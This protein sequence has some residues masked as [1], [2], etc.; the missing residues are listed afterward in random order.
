[1]KILQISAHYYPNLGGVETHLLDLV[2]GLVKRG[3]DIFVLTYRPLT[4]NVSWKVFEH[5]NKKVILRIPYLPGLFY[6]LVT[7]PILEFLYLFPGL[8]LALPFVIIYHNPDV[9]HSHGLVAGTV[10]IFWGKVFGKK[11]VISL[12]S[13]YHFPVN[14]LYRSFVKVVFKMANKIICL[15]KQS[16]KE[17]EDLGI[18]KEKIK[19]FTY[20]I[21]LDRFKRD[22]K[23]K[24]KLG[25]NGKFVILFVGRLIPEKG[26]LELLESVRSWSDNIM[27]VIIGSGPL[28][29][30]ITS[31]KKLVNNL[32]FLGEVDNE[33]LPVYYSAADLLIVPSVH[34]EGF[35]RVILESLACGT[36][37][38]GSNRGAVPEAM[39]GTVGK[40]IDVSPQNIKN[41]VE[42]F[43]KNPNK[44][45][46]L[47]SRARKFAITRFS[48]RNIRSIIESYS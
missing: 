46:L 23:A 25:W 45:R 19:V 38:V 29:D 39:D 31:Q 20:W 36:P 3:H 47:S 6:G 37:V 11:V 43:Y 13:I 15:S 17:V 4:T 9:I 40:L 26:I 48:E 32:I 7:S 18:L 33:R 30:F 16:A 5:E 21:D 41:S 14:G 2:N 44:L 35:G 22:N 42:S 34:E 27:L 12:H 8:F 10:S 24:E 1:M 28:E